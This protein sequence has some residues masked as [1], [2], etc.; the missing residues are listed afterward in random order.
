MSLRLA[1]TIGTHVT[2][3]T[4][5]MYY[6]A[7]G[8]NW[9]SLRNLGRYNIGMVF[10][11][12]AIRLRCINLFATS[13]RRVNALY[14]RGHSTLSAVIRKKLAHFV[15]RFRLIFFCHHA[16]TPSRSRNTSAVAPFDCEDCRYSLQ[17]PSLFNKKICSHPSLTEIF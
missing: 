2:R 11:R 3:E 12:L 15:F 14:D 7:R 4:P 10:C 6:N 16:L 1:S 9:T 8:T 13:R 17:H 5:S